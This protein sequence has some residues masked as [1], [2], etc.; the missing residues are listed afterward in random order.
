MATSKAEKDLKMDLKS[1]GY[2][3]T[4]G[5]DLV[6]RTAKKRKTVKKKSSSRKRK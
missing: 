6:K 2:R 4:H 5:Y 1:I 3:L